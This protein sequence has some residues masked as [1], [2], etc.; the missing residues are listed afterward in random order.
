MHGWTGTLPCD[1]SRSPPEHPEP[2]CVLACKALNIHMCTYTPVHIHI[3]VPMYFH[4]MLSAYVYIHGIYHIHICIQIHIKCVWAG[5]NKNMCIHTH[6]YIHI[7]LSI[8]LRTEKFGSFVSAGL[9]TTRRR[10]LVKCT[11]TSPRPLRP[12]L[13]YNF[14]GSL[15]TRSDYKLQQ[16]LDSLFQTALVSTWEGDMLGLTNASLQIPVGSVYKPIRSR[17][18][19]YICIPS[20][21]QGSPLLNFKRA[22]FQQSNRIASVSLPHRVYRN[23]S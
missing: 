2:T 3:Y 18:A 14:N 23:G 4:F 6:T 11:P 21:L 12:L 22:L 15:W 16:Y 7:Y 1:G 10:K 19:L 5:R 20:S 13:Q 17:W 9:F 8:Y